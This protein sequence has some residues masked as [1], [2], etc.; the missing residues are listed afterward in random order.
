MFFST[1]IVY[2]W[3]TQTRIVKV[4][5]KHADYLTTATAQHY[6]NC[7]HEKDFKTINEIDSIGNVK[8]FE[9][10]REEKLI[11]SFPD[12]NVSLTNTKDIFSPYL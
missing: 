4:R 7:P 11:I 12:E 6:F 5:G 9:G 2:L 3:S 8:N 10:K 1:K